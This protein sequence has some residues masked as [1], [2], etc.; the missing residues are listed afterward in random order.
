M[1]EETLAEAGGSIWTP[2]GGFDVVDEAITVTET[3]GNAIKF[4]RAAGPGLD[5]ALDGLVKAEQRLNVLIGAILDREHL[6]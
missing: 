4:L 2:S 1:P 3:I 6:Q 5:E